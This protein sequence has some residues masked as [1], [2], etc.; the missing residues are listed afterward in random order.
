M[1]EK[2]RLSDAIND[3]KAIDDYVEMK[4]KELPEDKIKEEALRMEKTHFSSM[5]A[6]LVGLVLFSIMLF[7]VFSA[8]NMFEEDSG[9]YGLF[10]VPIGIIILVIIDLVRSRKRDYKEKFKESFEDKLLDKI[11]SFTKKNSKIEIL[12]ILFRQEDFLTLNNFNVTKSIDLIIAGNLENDFGA[13]LLIDNDNKKFVL[14]AV[15]FYYSK[16]F[17]YKDLIGYEVYENGNSKLAGNSGDALVGGIL[18]GTTGAVIGSSSS[19][20]IDQNCSD[21]MMYIRIDDVNI[22]EIV[23]PFLIN[24]SIDKTSETYRT[25]KQHALGVG[26]AIE[27]MINQKMIKSENKNGKKKNDGKEA[28][29]VKEKLKQLKELLDEGLISEVEYKE[30]KNKLLDF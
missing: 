21:L 29:S 11:E 9:L 26:S 30:K 3:E 28:T 25:L 17:N 22:R 7:S 24:D 8:G 15:D 1:E 12:N 19:R 6:L 14:T 10:V 16:I 5:I 13:K 2:L 23:I 27:F 18:F 4:I 20:S